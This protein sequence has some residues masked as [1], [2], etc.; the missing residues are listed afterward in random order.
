MSIVW[1]TTVTVL[2]CMQLPHIS[3]AQDIIIFVC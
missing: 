2:P 1:Y 3:G